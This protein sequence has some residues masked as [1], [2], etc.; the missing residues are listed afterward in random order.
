[1]KCGDTARAVVVV[2][3]TARRKDKIF[4]ILTEERWTS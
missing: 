4:I 2:I 3:R 1:M